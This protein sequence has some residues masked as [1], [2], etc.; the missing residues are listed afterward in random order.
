MRRLATY[1]LRGLVLV[2]PV[3]V[4][5]YVCWAVF[6]RLDS[7]V[8]LRIPGA[9]FVLTLAVITLVGMLASN[10][11]TR[12][13]VTGID[14]LLA[15]LPFVRLLY[16]STKDLLSAFVGEHRRF[17]RPV[18]LSVASESGAQLLGFVTADALDDLGLAGHVAVYL[19]QAY[20]FAGNLVVVPADRVRPL[21]AESAEVMAFIVSGGVSRGRRKS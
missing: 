2:A 17:D 12:G 19:P 1:F 4:T 13:V 5:L 9:G 14:R 3:A 11:V 16:T 15:R 6:V 21:A 7:W 20:N 8:G 10:L 18:S